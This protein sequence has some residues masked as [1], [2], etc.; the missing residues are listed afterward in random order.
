[1]PTKPDISETRPR[2]GDSRASPAISEVLQIVNE[3]AARRNANLFKG[4]SL[5]THTGRRWFVLRRA[6][7]VG[8][9]VS[10]PVVMTW[11]GSLR[12]FTPC[13]TVTASTCLAG[14]GSTVADKRSVFPPR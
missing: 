5:T 4:R 3:L 10:Q 9:I 7:T 1:M 13:A 8:G 6:G 11:L 12:L 2:S 14:C